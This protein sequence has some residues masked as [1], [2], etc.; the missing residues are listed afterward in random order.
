MHR[1]AK[2]GGQSQLVSGYSVQ[3]ELS[4]GHPA[5]LEVLRQPFHVERKGGLRRRGA[6]RALSRPR[7]RREHC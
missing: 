4:A 2:S 3:R 5:E 6:D 7:R 1:P